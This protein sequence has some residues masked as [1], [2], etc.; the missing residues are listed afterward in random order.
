MTL[1]AN[2]PAADYSLKRGSVSHN[3]DIYVKKKTKPDWSFL[4]NTT[5]VF[6]YHTLVNQILSSN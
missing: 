6:V 4:F 2:L 3:Y 5:D 1:V